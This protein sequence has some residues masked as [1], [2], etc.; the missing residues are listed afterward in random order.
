MDE[1]TTPVGSLD[2]IQGKT[3]ATITLVEYG[4]YQSPQCGEAHSIVK[5]LMKEFHNELLFVFRNFPDDS[6]PEGMI[7]AQA[8]E[9]AALQNKF[10][11]MHDLIFEQQDQVS[12]SNL[13]YFAETLNLNIDQFENDYNSQN[14]IS[15]IESDIE[16]GIRSEVTDTPTF[17]IDD[18]RLEN[19]DETYESLAI[20]IRKAE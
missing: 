12:E 16:S 19:Y 17:F 13:I 5:K 15:K 3:S 20:A 7:A 4:D 14:V 2:H 10:W 18:E 9:A 6:R 1:L 11:E 8:A